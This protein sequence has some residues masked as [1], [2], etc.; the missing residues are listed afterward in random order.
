MHC[1]WNFMAKMKPAWLHSK[2]RVSSTLPSKQQPS[3]PIA[4]TSTL[5]CPNIAPMRNAIAI[6]AL[7]PRKITCKDSPQRTLLAPQVLLCTLLCT[8]RSLGSWS[9]E[10]HLAQRTWL[11]LVG[12]SEW[13]YGYPGVEQA[14]VMDAFLESVVYNILTRMEDQ[15]E[16]EKIR[17]MLLTLD[18]CCWTLVIS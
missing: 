18:S 8:L 15:D 12:D 6:A 4:F 3:S 5:D 11:E 1:V 7:T 9:V 10:Q 2:H 13:S 17:G 14:S 16:E